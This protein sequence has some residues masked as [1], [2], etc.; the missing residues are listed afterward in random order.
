LFKVSE[1]MNLAA[2][3][4]QYMAASADE[5]PMPVSELA[6]RMGVSES[7]LAKVMQRLVKCGFLGSTRGAKGGFFFRKSPSEISI[8]DVYESIEGPL[9]AP[10]CL[11]EKKLCANDECILGKLLEEMTVLARKRLGEKK[12]SDF[13]MET[14]P[15]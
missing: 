7:H 9:V 4:L 2:H 6:G 11:L 12:I 3:A 13:K 1:R 8:L 10:A 14:R 5:A 15:V